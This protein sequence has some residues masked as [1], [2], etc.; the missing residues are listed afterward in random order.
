MRHARRAALADSERAGLER[1]VRPPIGGV[2]AG[3]SHAYDHTHMIPKYAQK[4]KPR[5]CMAA[6]GPAKMGFK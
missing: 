4:D 5:L 2:R 6:Y 1:V 3:V